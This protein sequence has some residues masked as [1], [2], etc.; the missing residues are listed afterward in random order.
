MRGEN[1]RG[2]GGSNQRLL[3]GTLGYGRSLSKLFAERF[4]DITHDPR[5][6]TGKGRIRL[7]V[8]GLILG[9]FNLR[10][11]RDQGLGEAATSDRLQAKLNTCK[12]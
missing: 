4:A 9:R 7:R 1:A 10:L 12:Q 3:Q 5:E 2:P 8:L 6:P 11:K